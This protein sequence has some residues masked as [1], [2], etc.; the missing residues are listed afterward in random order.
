M[1]DSTARQLDESFATPFTDG[2]E[3]QIYRNLSKGIFA[4]ACGT[5]LED[6]EK[7]EKAARLFLGPDIEADTRALDAPEGKL[8]LSDKFMLY[9]RQDVAVAL[10]IC[11]LENHRLSG[12][13]T[14]VKTQ[15]DGMLSPR[16]QSL[17]N[18]MVHARIA[19]RFPL[20]TVERI[21]HVLTV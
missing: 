11:M 8:S 1:F 4:A 14:A 5:T 19:A 16:R 17:R 2:G 10:T 12:G 18:P 13:P 6:I 15:I 20:M 3:Q 9:G 7:A 21:K